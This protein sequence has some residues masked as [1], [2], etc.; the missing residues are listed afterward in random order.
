MAQPL[1]IKPAE[2]EFVHRVFSP[3]ANR[4][5][6]AIGMLVPF[7][8]FDQQAPEPQGSL[9]EAV[10][11]VLDKTAIL[12]EGW[13]K[14]KGEFLA[15]GSCYVPEGFTR[16]PVAA[17]VTVGPLS[18]R[19]AVFG[20]RVAGIGGGP[21]TPQAFTRMPLTL[22][23]AFGGEG[24]ARNPLGRGYKAAADGAEFPNVELPNHLMV[25]LSDTPP[26]ATLGPLPA[27]FQQ[28]TRHLGD[29]GSAWL[30]HRWPHLPLDTDAR[31][32]Q[33]AADDQ[34]LDG[35]WQGGEGIQ[36][37]NM[38][39][40]HSDIRAVVPRQR[41]RLFAHQKSPEGK[42]LFHELRV[43]RDTV[44]LLPEENLGIVIGRAVLPVNT[45]DASDVG[46]VLAAVESLDESPEPEESYLQTC[47]Q[48]LGVSIAAEKAPDVPVID[49][50]KLA[51]APLREIV[52]QVT[53]Q[54]QAFES[55]MRDAKID[56]SQ[57]LE[58]LE[59]DP[60][61][62]Q[63]ARSVRQ[64]GGSLSG[65][66][67]EIENLMRE[68]GEEVEPSISGK[69]AEPFTA[70][71]DAT[72]LPPAYQRPAPA[73]YAPRTAPPPPAMP[74]LD[75]LTLAAGARDRVVAARDSSG[76]C[77]GLNLSQANLAGLDLTGLDFSG[78]VLSGA[79]FSGARLG[80]CRFAGAHL[81]GARFDGADLAGAV[82]AQSS[83]GDATFC[84]A[85]LSGTDFSQ[86]DCTGANF[87]DA[88]VSADTNFTGAVLSRAW[89]KGLRAAGLKAPGAAFDNA[90]LD[91][92][93][94]SGATLEGA[95]F[96]GASLI[97][98]RF[99][100]AN[101]VKANFSQANAEG[102]DFTS[103]VMV[104]SQA[105][106]GASLAK[107]RFDDANLCAASWV[108]ADLSATSFARAMADDADF[109][110]TLLPG[111]VFV[112]GILRKACFDRA[113]LV[114]ADLSLC[115]L[116]QAS[117]LATNLENARLQ[118]S[119]LYGATFADTRLQGTRLE[120]ANIERTVLEHR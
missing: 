67:Q 32:F 26:P 46:A 96:S 56:E 117:F 15:A 25:S 71:A 98:A 84:G 76:S 69:Q 119:N 58:A 49:R 106:L 13:P 33:A 65:F 47:L 75:D 39:P 35:F 68:L 18:K 5:S 79:N 109:S 59:A 24:Y 19:L 115:N 51:N 105:S 21:S 38:H 10:S 80:G 92:A 107:A 23:N 41:L 48:G 28:R 87:A 91:A 95:D 31:F 77:E 111:A 44:W 112:R 110:D 61:T 6:L 78:A 36:I 34:Q 45:T 16:Q 104:Q 27:D 89:L 20:P 17:V 90:N 8:L 88:Q 50:S 53:E 100:G 30:K 43:N 99:S 55:A 120:G 74:A 9:W 82:F 73:P 29:Q 62:R 116:L 94:L 37:L 22:P 14:V 40:Q 85:G 66:F 70:V 2:L 114:G 63:I 64:S 7:R 83:L 97:A 54:R 3:E 57:F 12:D 118:E 72:E 60:H 102:A 42:P 52:Q 113:N 108:G 1:F 93:D 11:R 4:F 81:Q 86:A 103:A 101:C